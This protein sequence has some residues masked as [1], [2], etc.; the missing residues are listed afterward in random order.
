MPKSFADTDRRTR[1]VVG[2]TSVLIFLAAWEMLARSGLVNAYYTSRPSL[3]MQTGL[4]IIGRG[5]LADHGYISLAEFFAGFLLALG[6]GIP[7]GLIMGSFRNLRYLLDPPMIA[8]YTTPRLALLPILV[9][10]LGV[11]MESKIAVVFIGAVIP[12]L[13]NTIAGIREADLSLAQAARS[14]CA[15]QTDIFIKVLLPGSLPAVMTGIR[16]GLGR[17]VLG[18]VVGEMYVST[19]GIGYQI[20]SYG[21]A[22]RV[23]HLIFYVVLV[24]FFGFATTTLVRAIENHLRRWK[25]G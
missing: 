5:E 3:V 12:I 13:V 11:G 21:A 8:L 6:V 2:A 4:E 10:W 1:M 19:K 25:K 22:V 7:L 17:A 20:M 16:L 18:V 24:S 9:L 15:T 14:F 23:T